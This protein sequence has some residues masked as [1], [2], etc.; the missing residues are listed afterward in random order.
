MGLTLD[1]LVKQYE[2]LPEDKDTYTWT[3][4]RNGAQCSWRMPR[5]AV[6]DIGSAQEE[7]NRYINSNTKQDDNVPLQSC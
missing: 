4:H 5:F 2:P 1:L 7:I 6:A 3:D